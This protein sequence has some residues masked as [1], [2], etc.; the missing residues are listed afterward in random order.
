MAMAA[1]SL[2]SCLEGSR[3]FSTRSVSSSKL[4]QNSA[5]RKSLKSALTT[6]SEV[7]KVHSAA[8]LSFKLLAHFRAELL[9][10]LLKFRLLLEEFRD[11]RIQ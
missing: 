7:K 8:S 5:E 4:K 1:L 9:N 2:R 11:Q 6:D 10:I 3:S